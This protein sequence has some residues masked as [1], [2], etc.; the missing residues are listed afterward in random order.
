VIN[1][2]ILLFIIIVQYCIEN[3]NSFASELGTS[4]AT[5][6]MVAFNSQNQTDFISFT[7][8]DCCKNNGWALLN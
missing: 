6:L 1:K 5:F 8:A 3:A 7:D 2:I 4:S